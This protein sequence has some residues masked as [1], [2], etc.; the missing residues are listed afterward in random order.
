MTA[1]TVVALM[2]NFKINFYTI[3][4]NEFFETS[5]CKIDLS[6]IVK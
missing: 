3:E 6:G 1:K 2:P 5:E 4:K